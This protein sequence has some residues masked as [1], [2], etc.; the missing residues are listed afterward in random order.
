MNVKRQEG[1]IATCCLDE[2]DA[3]TYIYA[4]AITKQKHLKSH[5]RWS[6]A[7]SQEAEINEP[8][9]L[10]YLSTFWKQIK[11]R[12]KLKKSELKYR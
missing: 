10:K 7:L 8:S 11:K 3:T 2:V 12:Q 9:G 4:M 6:H 5:Y 1:G